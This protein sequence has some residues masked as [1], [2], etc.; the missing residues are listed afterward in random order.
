MTTSLGIRFASFSFLNQLGVNPASEKLKFMQTWLLTRDGAVNLIYGINI[1]SKFPISRAR[2]QNFLLKHGKILEKIINERKTNTEKM[3]LL[4]E[5][6]AKNCNYLTLRV[7]DQTRSVTFNIRYFHCLL[8]STHSFQSFVMLWLSF[9][10]AFS[11]VQFLCLTR[12]KNSREFQR[13]K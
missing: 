8:R 5:F 4:N 2:K 10:A 9:M 3:F 11:L 1:P 12:D 6:V 13:P 7:I